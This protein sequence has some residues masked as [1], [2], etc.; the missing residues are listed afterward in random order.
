MQQRTEIILASAS[1]Q[2]RTLLSQ[3]S[4]PFTVHPA[5][6]AEPTRP[7]ADFPPEAW[8]EALAYY[9]ASSV[10]CQFHECWVLGADTLVECGGRILGKPHDAEDACEMLHLQARNPARVITGVALLRRNPNKLRWIT[11]AETRVRLRNDLRAIER[12]VRSGQWRDKSGAYGLQ[13]A[14]ND[15]VEELDGSESN[16]VGL[17][18]D[19]TRRLLIRAGFRLGESGLR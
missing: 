12:Y 13:D 2:R 19:L 15:L 4:I 1:P 6:H 5:Q 16:V 10:A 7:P 3:L 17:P 14:E 9:K 18:L 8:A 11:H